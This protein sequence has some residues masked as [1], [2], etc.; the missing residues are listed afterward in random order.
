[1]IKLTR[2]TNWFCRG[3]GLLLV[4]TFLLPTGLQASNVITKIEIEGNQQIE[5]SSILATISSKVGM[6][7]SADRVRQDI[8]NLYQMGTFGDIQ[9]DK[10]AAAGGVLLTY[11]V[12]EKSRIG[13]ISFVGNKKVK[14]EKLREL[15]DIK[16][17]AGFSQNRIASAI[18]KIKAHY[19]EK[20][21]QLA[22]VAS[23]FKKI[24]DSNEEELIFRIHEHEPIKV[25]RVNFIGNK[26]FSDS[27]LRKLLKSKGQGFFSWL[28]QSGKYQE[29]AIKRDIAFLVYHYQNHGYLKVKVTAPK[30]Y[31]TRDRKWINLTFHVT[32]GEPYT[33]K[34]VGIEGDILTTQQ[35]LVG[36]FKTKPGQLYSREKMEEDLQLLSELY[37][38]QGYAF[39]NIN[40]Q[41]QTDDEK[42]TAELS[43]QVQKGNKISIEKIQIIGNTVTRDKVIRRELL[44][45]E[46]SLFS[47][48]KLKAS[49]Q[50][51]MQLGYFE[52]VNFATPRG[53][54]D[55]TIVLNITVKEK[56]TGTF[57]VGAGF[58]SAE[59]FIFTASVAKNNFFGYGISGQLSMELSSRR[60]LFVLSFENP[61]FLDSDWILGASG[62]RQVFQFTDFSRRSFGGNMTLGHHIFDNSTMRF[63]YGVEDVDVGSFST[64]VPQIFTRNLKGLT[65]SASMSLQRDTRDN[66][67]FPNKGMFQSATA[68]FAG[69]GGDNKYVRLTENFRFYYPI[70][71]K[72]VTKFN[73]TIS[74]IKSLND[75]PV[76]LFERFFLGGVNSLRGYTLRSV[77]PAVQ[78]PGVPA[79]GDNR[80]VFGGNKTL[81][82]N[83]E[84]EFPLYDPAGFKLVSFFDAGNAFSEEQN[85]SLKGLRT[86]YGFGLRWNSPFGPLRFEWGFPL[87]KQPGEESPVFNFT[88]GSFF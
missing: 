57:S 35:E 25:K 5:G 76:P 42:H 74:H 13:K 44:M 62:F 9:V 82:F 86:D 6:T 10:G 32:E 20:G 43:F 73:G 26:A 39:A 59:N 68:E 16:T 23:E 85:Y 75:L 41:I 54:S 77:G 15:L 50:R 53:S 45:K 12:V 65:S 80:F 17:T 83:L 69:L 71:R 1:M 31:L 3:L 30:S 8:K 51:L 78:I 24:P 79:G 61:H 22:E 36:K 49:R 70:W 46:N 66:R 14:E 28:T 2:K 48:T 4:V 38:D 18:A 40:P 29:E 52:D 63:T 21:Y 37:G 67:L 7:Y 88:I 72:L 81:Q 87:N 55:D 84:L 27:E 64:T 11:R 60:Q 47:E 34:T 58:S 56:P 33:L 19:E